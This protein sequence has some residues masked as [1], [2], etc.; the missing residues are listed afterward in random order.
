M[1]SK[2]NSSFGKYLF[3][4]PGNPGIRI[5]NMFPVWA[6]MS[7][8]DLAGPGCALLKFSS[9]QRRH[10]DGVCSAPTT[11]AT[12][13]SLSLFLDPTWFVTERRPGVKD[14]KA[15]HLTA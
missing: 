12:V 8:S 2:P 13:S 1:I 15:A 3:K 10:S 7:S 9:S 5:S 4:M 14:K 11:M 6:D